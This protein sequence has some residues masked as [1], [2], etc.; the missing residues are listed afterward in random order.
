MDISCVTLSENPEID[1]KNLYYSLTSR[2][3][4]LK[5]AYDIS[6]A[7]EDGCLT[8]Q[9]SYMPYKTG[10]WPENPDAL[11]VCA[12]RKGDHSCIDFA[13]QKAEIRSQMPKNI[14][15]AVDIFLLLCYTTLVH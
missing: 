7:V 11:P 5:Y 10:D 4:E 13:D 2:F 14:G 1:V 15:K 6:A 8:C 3:P 12:Y 9:I